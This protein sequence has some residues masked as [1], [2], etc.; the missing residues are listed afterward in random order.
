M[1]GSARE[2]ANAVEEGVAF[3]WLAAPH[4]IET[5]DGKAVRVLAQR[6]KLSA[7]DAS[8]RQG[9]EAVPGSEFS[10]DAD[11]AI[12]AL[13]FEPE[14]LPRLFGEEALGVTRRGT[15][16]LRPGSFETTADRIYAAGDIVRGASLVVWAIHDGREAAAEIIDNLHASPARLAAE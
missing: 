15:L 12:A 2:V 16:R 9:I 6:M 4:A 11:M 1:P 10:I 5:R 13:G 8:G 14:D 3:E 7:A